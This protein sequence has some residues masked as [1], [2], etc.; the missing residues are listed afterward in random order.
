MNQ[1]FFQLQGCISLCLF[2]LFCQI[3]D[4]RAVDVLV[5]TNRT[6]IPVPLLIKAK[7]SSTGRRAKF[8]ASVPSYRDGK[9]TGFKPKLFSVERFKF[10]D[11]DG[12]ALIASDVAKLTPKMTK[13][14]LVEGYS[15][16][17]SKDVADV[18]QT[19]LLAA[20]GKADV[21]TATESSGDLHSGG[22]IATVNGLGLD[23][24]FPSCHTAMDSF[25]WLGRDDR[26][27]GPVGPDRYGWLHYDLGTV[28]QIVGLRIWNYNYAKLIRRSVRDIDVYV[29]TDA[30]AYG[31]NAHASWQRVAELKDI[32]KGPGH[33]TKMPYGSDY[34]VQPVSG[35]F[36]RLDVQRNWGNG[37]NTAFAEVQFFATPDESVFAVTSEVV[38]EPMK[39]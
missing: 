33:L 36:I 12:K 4:A 23:T 1:R 18:R 35:R 6:H 27:Q 26:N 9:F 34:P 37:W 38:T 11:A 31:D 10:Y 29:S 2:G 13:V 17:F 15:G 8:I 5:E 16:D 22:A 20:G 21:I 14:F 32:P 3:G 30:E 24:T 7:V 28:Q 39:R 19:A 25:G